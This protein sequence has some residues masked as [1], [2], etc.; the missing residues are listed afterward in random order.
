MVGL[1]WGGKSCQQRRSG[2]PW[3]PGP[4]VVVWSMALGPSPGPSEH[5]ATVS[6]GFCPLLTPS[7]VSSWRISFSLVASN[8]SPC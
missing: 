4:E 3:G 1:R 5:D 7:V 2:C 8:T 6:K